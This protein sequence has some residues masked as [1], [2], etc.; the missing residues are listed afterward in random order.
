M[1]A[2]DTAT[3][4]SGCDIGLA[5]SHAQE[6]ADAMVRWARKWKMKTAGEKTQALVL[7]QRYQDARDFSIKVAGV[8]VAGQPHLKLLGVVFDLSL[9]FGEHCK[10]LSRSA[11]RWPL[12]PLA[13]VSTYA[14]GSLWATA[15]RRPAREKEEQQPNA[16]TCSISCRTTNQ[17]P[18]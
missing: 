8:E 14:T 15:G 4:S 9:H 7:S 10:Q 16:P 5:R 18:P 11:A 3:L 12:E 6:A 2:D 17:F 1:Y 13:P